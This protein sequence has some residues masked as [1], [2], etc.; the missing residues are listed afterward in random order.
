MGPL[1]P[2]SAGDL[3]KR[4][5]ETQCGYCF[6]DDNLVLRVLSYTNYHAGLVQLFGSKL[7]EKLHKRGAMGNPRY[8]IRAE[9]VQAVYGAIREDIRLRFDWTLE[10]DPRYQVIAWT[11]LDDEYEDRGSFARPYAVA[12]VRERVRK[13]WPA[14]FDTTSNDQLQSS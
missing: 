11:I 6:T 8:E 3:L 7:L 9:V 2:L 4:P 1:D 5:L 12:T 13:R 10:L 14:G